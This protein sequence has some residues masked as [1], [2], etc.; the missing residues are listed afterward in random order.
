MSPLLPP[1]LTTPVEK[2]IVPDMPLTTEPDRKRMEP[3]WPALASREAKEIPPDDNPPA[4]APD[5]METRP[6]VLNAESPA[7]MLTAAPM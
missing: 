3:L 2:V 6:P 4:P 7:R 1:W 5:T